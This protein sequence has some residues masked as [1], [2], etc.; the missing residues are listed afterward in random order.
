MTYYI[1]MML[2]VE[3]AAGAI[4]SY[5]VLFTEK[6]FNVHQ[7]KEQRGCDYTNTKNY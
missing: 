4:F 6:R 1:S 5:T 7:Q 2:L 3:L